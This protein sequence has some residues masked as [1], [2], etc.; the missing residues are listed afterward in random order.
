MMWPD[1][2]ECILEYFYM[3]KWI[4]VD[5][6][7]GRLLSAWP[8]V[9]KWWTLKLFSFTQLLGSAR[10]LRGDTVYVGRKTV[11]TEALWTT[12]VGGKS[13]DVRAGLR[14]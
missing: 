12:Y 8:L 5:V 6:Q 11:Q 9:Q 14:T 4:R 2:S 3:Y 7:Q 1:E 13:Y 10:A